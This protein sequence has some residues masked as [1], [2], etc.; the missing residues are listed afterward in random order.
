[1]SGAVS[2]GDAGEGLTRAC[3]SFALDGRDN[4]FFIN[5]SNPA[6]LLGLYDDHLQPRHKST[7]QHSCNKTWVNE[8]EVK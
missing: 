7:C 4:A 5:R 6:R 2:G 1:M 3:V 8:K